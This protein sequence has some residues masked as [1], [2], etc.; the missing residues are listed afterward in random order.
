M[1]TVNFDLVNIANHP[2]PNFL[3]VYAPYSRVS[4]SGKVIVSRFQVVEL[5]DGQGS[6]DVHEGG[7]MT[8]QFPKEY[9]KAENITVPVP[10]GTEP[11]NFSD[12]LALEPLT[13]TELLIPAIDAARPVLRSAV[14]QFLDS[15]I[16]IEGDVISIDGASTPPLTGPA[17]EPGSAGPAGPQG[18]KGDRGPAGATGARGPAGP[19][20]TVTTQSLA[21]HPVL[22]ID[23]ASITRYGKLRVLM[24]NDIVPG[25]DSTFSFTLAAQD[26]PK[27]DLSLPFGNSTIT[28]KTTGKV[29]GAKETHI[30]QFIYFV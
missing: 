24:L 27:A 25:S 8:V 14:Q 13:D 22:R 29:E 2:D 1:R 4:R 15:K 23:N 9:G 21:T 12:L 3:I 19:D 16:S 10:A 18:V 6:I 7:Y 17:G 11:I 5:V 20:Y 28:I 30:G 26:R